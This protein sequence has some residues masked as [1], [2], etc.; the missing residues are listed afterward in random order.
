MIILSVGWAYVSELRPPTGLLFIHQVMY[1][2]GEPRWINIDKGKLPIRPPEL[3]GHP[4][5]NHLVVSQEELLKKLWFSPFELSLSYFE[6]IFTCCKI[7]R[8]G[9]DFTSPQKK[10]CCGFLLPLKMC[11]SRPCLSPLNWGPMASTLTTRPPRATSPPPFILRSR[12]SHRPWFGH[13]GCFN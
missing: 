12:Q 4:T 8:Y 9:D 7:L 5:S 13:P 10:A 3:S 11:R 1:V 6:G 2:H